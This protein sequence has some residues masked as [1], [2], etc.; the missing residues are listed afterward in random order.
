MNDEEYISAL[1]KENKALKRETEFIK[2]IK[3]LVIRMVEVRCDRE[4][5]S[6]TRALIKMDRE[7][8]ALKK[9]VKAQ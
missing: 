3:G 7:F 4:K 6:A 9:Q 5:L 2:Q 8:R 1:E